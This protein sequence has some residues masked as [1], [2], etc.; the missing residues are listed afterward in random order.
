MG[1]MSHSVSDG[2]T[3]TP[4]TDTPSLA[5]AVLSDSVRASRQVSSALATCELLV[6]PSIFAVGPAF[7]ECVEEIG[8]TQ[9]SRKVALHSVDAAL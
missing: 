1:R 9:T 8:V 6:M 7:C 5:L 4:R 2:G 3:R